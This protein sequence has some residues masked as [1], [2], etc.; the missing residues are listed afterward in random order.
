M[1]EPVPGQPAAIADCGSERALVVA[2]YHAGIEVGL[3]RDGVELRSNAETR[4]ERLLRLLVETDA[5]RVVFLGDLADAI[6]EPTGAERIELETLLKT[7]TERVPVTITKGNHD[8]SI[9]AV[10]DGIS[11]VTVVDGPGTRIGDVGFCHGHTWPAEEVAAAPALCT[12]H[13][14]PQVRLE[15]EVGGSRTERVWLRGGIDPAGFPDYDAVGDRMVVC[16]AFNDRSG[17]TFVNEADGFLSPFLPDGLADGEAYLLDG[18]RLG[19]YK[20]I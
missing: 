10:T 14:H 17:G 4:R 11:D 15:D 16:P 6:G 12:A 8:G 5:D 13:E 1:I 9:E 18:T 2:D 3:R 20:S 19:Y 7:V